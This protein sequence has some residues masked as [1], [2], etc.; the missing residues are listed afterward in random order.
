MGKEVAE[1]GKK[2]EVKNGEEN[3]GARGCG[4]NQIPVWLPLSMERSLTNMEQC[5]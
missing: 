5:I 1:P 3:K 4:N 2:T